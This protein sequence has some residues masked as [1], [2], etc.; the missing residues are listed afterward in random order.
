M[1]KRGE[2][3]AAVTAVLTSVAQIGRQWEKLLVKHLCAF[4]EDSPQ[5]PLA[6]LISPFV[7]AATREN[8]IVHERETGATL[9]NLESLLC[10][11]E[12]L[13][14]DPKPRLFVD[15][16][17][18]HAYVYGLCAIAAWGAAHASSMHFR[19]QFDRVL[20]F[21]ERAG[22]FEGIRDPASDPVRF[23]TET[24][25]GFTRID[26]D[27]QF[28]TDSHA[29]R[30]VKL[31]RQQTDMPEKAARALSISFAEL[32]ENAVKHGDIKAPAWL[33]AN[34][35]PQHRIMHVCICDRGLGVRKTFE[36]ST[37]ERLRMLAE[38]ATEWLRE[39]T[40]PL[41]T[42]KAER[43]AGYGLY[44]ASELCRRNGGSFA[45]VSGGAAYGIHRQSDASAVSDVEEIRSLRRPWRGTLVALQL[46][47]DHPLELGPIYEQLPSPE[48]TEAGPED[49]ELFDG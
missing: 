30:L 41:V 48:S 37:D 43:H 44:V 21:L 22:F 12:D 10:R 1:C 2:D 9:P 23:D 6:A 28:P 32:I 7:D 42:S 39:A 18:P 17:T 26:P 40:K 3:A 11:L 27:Q 8:L 14:R 19:S 36:E 45:I 13:R 31:F 35:H 20:H 16:Q 25:L 47:L 5:D 38:D 33:F 49:M 4:Q 34:Y 29:G 15:F 46:R 24:I